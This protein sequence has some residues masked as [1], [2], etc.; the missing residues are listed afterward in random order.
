MNS[1]VIII[2]AGP[3][4][5]SAAITL[6]SKNIKVLV[7]DEYMKAGGRLA[8]QLYEEKKG[9]WWNGLKETD[10]LVDEA[11]EK[12]AKIQL[13]TSVFN[14]EKMD[15]SWRVHTNKGLYTSDFLLL[16]TG[17]SEKPLPVPGWTLPGVMSV[18]AA[19][20]LTN[21]HRVKPG[22]TG[23]IVGVN[24]LSSVIT[25]EL[26]EAKIHIA[27]MVLPPYSI[28][29]EEEASPQKTLKSLA[30][31]AHMAPSKFIQLGSKL[32]PYA[33]IQKL[34]ISLYPKSGIKMWNV[35]ILLRKTIVEILGTEEVTGVRLANIT[36]EG[37]V[38]P[39]TE[40][41]IDCDFVCIS[42]GLSPL[43]ELA[44]LAGCSI[45][46]FEALGGYIPIHDKSMRTT[47]EGL[48][49]AGNIIG[50]EGAKVAMKQGITAAL[51]IS[52]IIL[53][54]D[55]SNMI[56]DSIDATIETRKS[57]PIQFN[58]NIEEGRELAQKVYE[59]QSN[60]Q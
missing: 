12:G 34:A 36:T 10:K 38:I 13:E 40:K 55:F 22:N 2:G 49:V 20:I 58:I 19:Q 32:L 8:G 30:Y 27:A 46:Y 51:S 48:Y 39:N 44:S 59:S 47:V 53:K 25:M 37:T 3:A 6:A 9:V 24:V 7:I 60:N 21:V 50:I 41:I 11:L 28:P 14:L 17:A 33:F 57:S 18:G 1:T 31:V 56:H 29:N 43:I 26:I 15:N 5:L 52:E 54:Q 42:G 35:P 23:V 45:H 16:A 4:G